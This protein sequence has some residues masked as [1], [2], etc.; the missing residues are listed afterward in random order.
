MKYFSFKVLYISVFA[1][2]ILY[3]LTLPYL[4]HFLQQALTREI[5]KNMIRHELTLMEGKTSLYEEVNRNVSETLK[6]SYAIR[7]GLEVRVRIVDENDNVIYPYYEYLLF[8]LHVQKEKGVG[9]AGALFDAKGFARR[10]EPSEVEDFLQAF[11]DYFRGMTVTVSAKIPVTSWI[12]S[13]TLLLYI[14]LTLFLL[15]LYYRRTSAREEKRL[16]EITESL[17]AEKRTA[18][19]IES[20]LHVARNR[21]QEIQS[22]EEEWL[23]EVE[24]LEG[25]KHSLEDELLDT[26]E[27]TEE[28]KEII[29]ELKNQVIKK[30]GKKSKGVKEEEA[31]SSRFSKLYRNLEF[32][33]KALEDLVR[34]GSKDRQ[35][36]AEEILKRLNDKD[37]SLKVRRKIAGIEKCDAYELG[38]GSSGRIYYLAARNG[39][40]RILRIGTKTS[41]SKD[42]AYLQGMRKS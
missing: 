20:E 38:F 2:S 23:K 16:R 3:L 15:S 8:T 35:L 39:K 1:P 33:R 14:A 6:K 26:L 36:Q 18:S 30:A 31:L 4:E 22:Q 9:T 12:G 32:D 41:Q 5:R 27:Q 7:A 42:L 25:E 37:P 29:G 19:Q 13:G 21:L 10:R 11:S 17:E 34:L 24:R 28:Q 40:Y